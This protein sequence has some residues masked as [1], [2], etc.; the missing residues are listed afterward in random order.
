MYPV[1]PRFASAVRR[2]HL[3]ATLAQ[4]TDPS[5]AVLAEL[6]C[7]SGSVSAETERTVRRTCSVTIID[8]T[9][10]LTPAEAN[11]LLAPFGNELRLWRGV[12]F[13]ANDIELVPLG[14]FG[15]V[16][17]TVADADDGVKL[18]ISGQDR[19]ARISAAKFTDPYKVPRG[20]DVSAAITDLL[21]SRWSAVTIDLPP[22]E[23]VTARTFLEAG[24]SSDPWRDAQELAL[25]AGYVLAFDVNG[26]VRYD[27]P[28]P[29]PVRVYTDGAEAALLSLERV[30]SAEATRNG[31]IATG[32]GT[33]LI[34]P[35]RGEAWDTDRS[36]PTYVDGKFGPRPAFLSSPLIVTQSQ[37]TRVA[38][39]QLDQVRGV[40]HSVSWGALVDAALDVGD[41]VQIDRPTSRTNAVVRLDSLTVPLSAT[42]SM[43]AAGRVVQE[44]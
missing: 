32:E 17:S 28:T 40:A 9:G 18:S 31:V 14:V 42:D 4:V 27:S 44:A 38:E 2:T 10:A 22:A 35:V 12:R 39:R 43:S 41:S 16:E 6:T 7:E 21:Q 37:A 3:V 1:T 19:A 25:S 24:D 20:Q 13:A 29:Q 23:D 15:F 11:D 5:G 26:V 8:P 33:D 36:S 34:A 30:M